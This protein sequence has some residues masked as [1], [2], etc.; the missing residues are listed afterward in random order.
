MPGR[1]RGNPGARWDTGL[2]CP[3]VPP[4]VERTPALAA[5]GKW[6]QVAREE[7]VPPGK[8]YSAA[9]EAVT[10]VAWR[11]PAE[12]VS[13]TGASLVSAWTITCA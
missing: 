6:W 8:Y 1:Q 7:P 10:D 12:A 9:G 3:L 4:M 13:M 2:R 5:G 11:P